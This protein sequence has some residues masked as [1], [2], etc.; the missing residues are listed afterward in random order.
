MDLKSTEFE[1]GG[2]IWNEY[3]VVRDSPY[4]GFGIFRWERSCTDGDVNSLHGGW[5]SEMWENEERNG[6]CV[7]EILILILLKFVF[8]RA[9]WRIWLLFVCSFLSFRW[10]LITH[11]CVYWVHHLIWLL[12]QID[13]L[14]PKLH[15]KLIFLFLLSKLYFCLLFNFI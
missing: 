5:E 3:G 14:L 7:F 8:S 9:V 4:G 15:N 1:F 6:Y 13:F 12:W 2:V 11:F 10:C